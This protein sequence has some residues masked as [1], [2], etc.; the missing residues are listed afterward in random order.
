MVKNMAFTID[1]ALFTV[2]ISASVALAIFGVKE[3]LIE[4]QRWKK[5]IY[6]AQIEKRLEVYGTLLT[7]LQSFFEK[8]HRENFKKPGV[9]IQLMPL[10]YWKFHLMQIR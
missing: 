6:I 5:N 1:S 3:K 4:P 7:L 2:L 8:A 9:W 10:T